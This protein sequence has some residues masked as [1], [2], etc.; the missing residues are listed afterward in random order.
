MTPLHVFGDWLR[1][2][3]LQIPLGV[4]RALFVGILVA[5][6]IWV[7]TLPRAQ[8]VRGD[9]PARLSENLKIWAAASLLIQ[10]V[11]YLLL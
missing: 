2:L 10:I 6:L 9:G 5:L 7:L 11:I 8:T 3:M 1:G 4:A